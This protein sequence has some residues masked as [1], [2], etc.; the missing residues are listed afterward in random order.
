[1]SLIPT[2]LGDVHKTQTRLSVVCVVAAGPRP[3]RERRIVL[4]AALV[5]IAIVVIAVVAA[6]AE[7]KLSQTSAGSPTHAYSADPF[8]PLWTTTLPKD[9][10]FGGVINNLAYYTIVPLTP[11]LNLNFFQFQVVAFSIQDGGILWNST[12]ISIW[13]AGNVAPQLVL[14]PTDLYLVGYA[15]N[16]T[17]PGTPWNGTGGVFSIGFDLSSGAPGPFV[18]QLD[19]AA[20]QVGQVEVSGGTVYVGYIADGSAVL[21]AFPLP[22]DAQGGTAWSYDLNLPAG[23]SSNLVFSVEDGYELVLLS[24]SLAVLNATDGTYLENV[25]FSYPLNLFDGTVLNGVAY[26]INWVGPN[27]F[28]QGFDLAT[29]SLVVNASLGAVGVPCEPF[30]VSHVS[31]VLLASASCDGVW[32]AYTET[33]TYLWTTSVASTISALSAR[34]IPIGASEVL[35]YSP[36]FLSGSPGSPNEGNYSFQEW[37]TLYNLTTGAVIWQENPWFQVES[38]LAL[39]YS[40]F[41]MSE[42]PTPALEAWYSDYV[43]EWW[44]G[45]TGLASI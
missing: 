5:S 1:M 4:T 43:V 23:F 16:V 45:S 17:D 13:D 36:L 12:P 14:G 27:L 20:I 26:G 41:S 28:L 40:P 42:P 9:S 30:E 2:V 39:T 22:G 33:G 24:T 7:V 18:S 44:G 31:D 38:N 29:G 6:F 34:P 25:P 37:F 32:S 15:S 3:P 35:I 10:A 8:P 11:G 21:V 19:V